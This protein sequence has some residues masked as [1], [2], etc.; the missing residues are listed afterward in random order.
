MLL[1]LTP[2]GAL[3]TGILMTTATH[4]PMEAV[5]EAKL[6]RKKVVVGL[7]VARIAP[8][9]FHTSRFISPIQISYTPLLTAS[10]VLHRDPSQWLSILYIKPSLESQSVRWHLVNQQHIHTVMQMPCFGQ[11]QPVCIHQTLLLGKIL[12]QLFIMECDIWDC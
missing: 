3:L 5:A 6:Q 8:N 12:T 1:I 7:A 10:L 4:I 9:L 11:K 2:M